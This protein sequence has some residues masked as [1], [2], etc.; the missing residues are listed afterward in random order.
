MK[1]LI[2]LRKKLWFPYKFKLLRN[3]YIEELD[4]RPRDEIWDRLQQE[5][6]N[7]IEAER[8]MDL[9]EQQ[10]YKHIIETLNWIINDES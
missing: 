7:L 1:L 2:K 3:K 8:R 9:S 4:I 5:K 10:K 6:R